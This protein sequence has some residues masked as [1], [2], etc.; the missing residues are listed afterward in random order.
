MAYQNVGTPRFYINYFNYWIQSGLGLTGSTLPGDGDGTKAI[1]LISMNPASVQGFDFGGNSGYWGFRINSPYTSVEQFDLNYMA[2]LGHNLNS[3]NASSYPNGSDG[4]NPD[5]FT[6]KTEIV[7]W[8]NSVT[9][10]PLNG[11]SLME[12]TG[13]TNDLGF[14]YPGFIIH[15]TNGG[16]FNDIVRIGAVSIGRYYEM[17]H[18]PDLSLSMSHEYDGIKKIQ[19]KGGSTLSNANFHKPPK[20]GDLE[21]WQLGTWQQLSSGRRSWDLSFTYISDTDIEPRNYTGLKT[22]GEINDD[23][24]F[25]NVLYYTMGGHLPFIFQPDKDATYDS[26]TYTVPEFAICRFDMNSFKRTQIS[27][28]TYNIK[29]KIVE[30]W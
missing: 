21:A 17:P 22:D 6:E 30:S 29:V 27:F 18:S 3:A 12:F 7:N 25:Q 1:N 23:N 15:D 13:L 10:L 20:W 14:L 24:W 8:E 2:V 16:G 28:K 11:W 19:T 4:S 9:S 26:A 5:E